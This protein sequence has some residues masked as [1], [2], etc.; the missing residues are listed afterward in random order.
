MGRAPGGAGLRGA[1]LASL[2]AIGACAGAPARSSGAPDTGTAAA[3]AERPIGSTGVRYT[4]AWDTTGVELLGPGLRFTTDLGYDVHLEYGLLV[5]AHAALV[6]CEDVAARRA[7]AGAVGVAHAGHGVFD[8]PSAVIRARS[9]ALHAPETVILGEVSYE[10]T[11]HCRAHMLAAPDLNGDGV[12][13]G[14]GGAAEGDTG[15]ADTGGGG[16]GGASLRLRGSARSPEGELLALD[17]TG[18]SAFGE[19]WTLAHLDGA[20]SLPDEPGQLELRL[21]R[22]LA[23]LLDGIDLA[24][25]SPA[26]I[27]AG[28]LRNALTSQSPTLRAVAR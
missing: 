15:A 22:P 16:L 14:L 28:V 6:P 23:R 19:L 1:L 12:G 13:L 27:S 17:H 9:E 8:D 25:A 3:T 26:A 2:L 18:D 10:A 5:T 24:T 7:A 20:D 11:A 21:T 4:L